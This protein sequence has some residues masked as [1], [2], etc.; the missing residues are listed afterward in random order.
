[1]SPK[2][3]QS[4]IIRRQEIMTK[5]SVQHN[6]EIDQNIAK[7]NEILSK[8]QETPITIPESLINGSC[9]SVKATML[10]KL[11]SST[12]VFSYNKEDKTYILE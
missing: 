7:I 1:M 5:L 8:A 6:R 3:T 11:E 12:W 2:P 4:E 9:A 10:K